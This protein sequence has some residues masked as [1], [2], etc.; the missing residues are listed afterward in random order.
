[1]PVYHS[2][3]SLIVNVCQ[4]QQLTDKLNTTL[5]LQ[6]NSLRRYYPTDSP[7]PD[8]LD[9]IASRILQV[10]EATATVDEQAQGIDFPVWNQSSHVAQTISY[11]R[12]VCF[13]C[14]SNKTNLFFFRM[15]MFVPSLMAF[16]FS[17]VISRHHIAPVFMFIKFLT[18][19]LTLVK[20]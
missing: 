2:C 11:Y 18:L 6:L 13:N 9:D 5:L 14:Q 10:L 7:V 19:Y 12:F 20:I 3:H 15:Q 16:R 8:T 4:N 17:T 1:M